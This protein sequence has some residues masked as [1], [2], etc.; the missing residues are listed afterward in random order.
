LL[1]KHHQ[2]LSIAELLVATGIL[3]VVLVTVMT[4]FGQLLKNT[5]KNA[6]LSAGSFFADKVIEKQVGVAQANLNT[7]KGEPNSNKNKA[8]ELPGYSKSGD[9]YTLSNAEGFLAIGAD[10]P[11]TK[12]LYKVEA[13]LVDGTL[14]AD[15]GQVWSLKVEVRWWQDTTDGTAETRAGSGKLS[16]VRDQLVYFGAP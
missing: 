4:L 14:Q 9:L 13:L 15:P 1:V 7:H 8:F 3:A 16:V 12:Y 6:L 5:N 11:T 10:G 2:G